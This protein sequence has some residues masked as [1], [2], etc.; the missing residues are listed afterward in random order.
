MPC[1]YRIRTQTKVCGYQLLIQKN[2]GRHRGLPLQTANSPSNQFE[3]ATHRLF[4]FIRH[5]S[6]VIVFHLSSFICHLSLSFKVY[7]VLVHL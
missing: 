1:P 4:V 5:P 7:K 2:Q 6:S 3:G